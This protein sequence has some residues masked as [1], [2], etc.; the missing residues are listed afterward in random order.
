MWTRVADITR[1]SEWSPKPYRVELVSGDL[2]AAGSRY[3]SVGWVPPNDGNHANDVEI[4]E[5][6]P[7]SRFA[8]SATDATGTYANSFDLQSVDGGTQITFHIAFP[9]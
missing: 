6:V 8:L 4:T 7:M 3:R 2:N 9:P 5:V 1:H